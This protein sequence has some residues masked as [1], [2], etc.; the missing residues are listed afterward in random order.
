MPLSREEAVGRFIVLAT[1]TVYDV[2]DKMGYPNQALSS[3]IRPLARGYRLAGPAFTVHGTSTATYDGQRGSAMSY[4]MFRS[5]RAGD[6]IVFDTGGH[7]IGGPWGANTGANAKARGAAGIVLDGG[8]RD[9][10]DLVDLGFPAYCRFTTPVLAHGRFQVEGFNVPISVSGQVQERVRVNPEDFVLGDDDGVVVVPQPL[11]E[12]VLQ[13]SEAATL[14]ETEIR[15][16]LEAGEDREDV[17]RR[18]DRWAL[19]KKRRK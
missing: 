7:K 17:D 4:T 5:I 19:L 13:Y 8:T 18:I 14:A 12:E 6:V 2:L 1:A 16:A 9:A 3:A 10:R 15:N 11:L